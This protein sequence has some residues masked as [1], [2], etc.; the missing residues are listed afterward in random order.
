MKARHALLPAALVLGFASFS[1]GGKASQSQKTSPAA[2]PAGQCYERSST[3]GADGD[4]APASADSEGDYDSDDS[5]F[6]PES[7]AAVDPDL[8]R[9][10]DEISRLWNEI[11]EQRLAAG[12]PAEP[13]VNA[14]TKVMRLSV[15]EIQAKQEH[16]EPKSQVCID[17]CKIEDS[18][19]KNADSICRLSDNLG[20]NAWAIEKCN[21]G[22]ASC[23]EAN[24]K[25]AD[26]VAGEST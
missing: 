20:E 18:I 17:T 16:E 3:A 21:S 11:R 24:Q 1:C 25:C 23:Q 10:E 14:T 26:C 2:Q 15:D 4:A 8:G 6:A 9:E 7:A 19:C 22:K 12:L 5:C 13:L